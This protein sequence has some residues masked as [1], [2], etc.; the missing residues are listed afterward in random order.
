MS[1]DDEALELTGEKIEDRGPVAMLRAL[2]GRLRAQPGLV[3]Y[4][5]IETKTAPSERRGESRRP[6][7]LQSG[8]I[9]D[10]RERFLTEF[11]FRN[12][13]E[14]GMRLRLAQ[15]VALPRTVLLFDDQSLV[16]VA[17]SVVWQ[18]GCDAGCRVVA[19]RLAAEE[20]LMARLKNPYYAVR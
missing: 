11:V 7:H 6:V 8:K 1:R 18:H 16:L 9:V 20:R 12:R 4:R 15:R 5:V 10:L 2:T 17:A 13:G 14:N 19:G 3:T